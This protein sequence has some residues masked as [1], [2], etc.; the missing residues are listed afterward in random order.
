MANN[1]TI[2]QYLQDPSIA[3]EKRKMMVE[4]L[5]SGKISESR[6]AELINQGY[7]SRK[8]GT[9]DNL[10]E[11][12]NMLGG[13]KLSSLDP[14]FVEKRQDFFSKG[15]SPGSEFAAPWEKDW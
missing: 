12:L 3:T 2:I 6:A 4:D 5:K 14:N 13:E 1:S 8:K 10:S 7:V 11:A 15:A 9:G